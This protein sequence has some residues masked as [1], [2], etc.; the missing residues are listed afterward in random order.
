[1]TQ[2]YPTQGDG[3][4]APGEVAMPTHAE[5]IELARETEPWATWL[6]SG[7]CLEYA[8]CELSDLLRAAIALDR[9]RR[10]ENV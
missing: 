2:D 6:K 4:V 3:A 8:P 1:M 5:L 7:G 9:S 10:S